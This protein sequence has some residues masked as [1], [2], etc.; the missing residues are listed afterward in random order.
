MK[1][2]NKEKNTA[3]NGRIK[4]MN[5]KV[6]GRKVAEFI[7]ALQDLV[8]CRAQVNTITTCRFT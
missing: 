1:S 8:K 5:L 6:K 3:I 4:C 2:G 7:P